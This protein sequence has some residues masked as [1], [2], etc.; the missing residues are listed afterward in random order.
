MSTNFLAILI[1]WSMRESPESLYNTYHFRELIKIAH[2]TAPGSNI[3]I[4]LLFPPYPSLWK[5]FFKITKGRITPS[6]TSLQ[7]LCLIPHSNNIPCIWVVAI[8]ILSIKKT[9]SSKKICVM[10]NYNVSQL[11][12][13]T[14]LIYL[15]LIPALLSDYIHIFWRFAEN[16]CTRKHNKV[17]T[18]R[19]NITGIHFL[20]ILQLVVSPL[21]FIIYPLFI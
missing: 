12:H 2:I 3:L 5:S 15:P 13:Q 20:R 11:K 10:C 6:L 8:I 7:S 14:T 19:A 4:L 1:P 9:N 18:K 21:S 16:L 17:Q